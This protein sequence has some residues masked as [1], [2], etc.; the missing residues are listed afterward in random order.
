M[1]R[2]RDDDVPVASR[3]GRRARCSGCPTTT[4]SRRRSSSATRCTAI[5][6][7]RRKPVAAFATIDRFDGEHVRLTMT[8]STAID[9]EWAPDERSEC[10]AVPATYQRD[11]LELKTDGLTDAAGADCVGAHRASSRS[12]GSSGT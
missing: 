1:A 11:T 4:R 5:T 2:R 9:P 7:L 3:A 8:R 10:C 12:P 6:K